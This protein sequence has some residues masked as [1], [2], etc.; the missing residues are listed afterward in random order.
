MIITK[1]S[2]RIIKE[3]NNLPKYIASCKTSPKQVT[4]VRGISPYRCTSIH[5]CKY[6]ICVC[7]FR[8]MKGQCKHS[9]THKNT[10]WCQIHP[11]ET[12]VNQQKSTSNEITHF[13]LQHTVT[14]TGNE[15]LF[16]K[17]WVGLAHGTTVPCLYKAK[18]YAKPKTAEACMQV[19]SLSTE[20]VKTL[21]PKWN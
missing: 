6:W 19:Y 12:W 10:W 14:F 13:L 15:S 1:H 3:K 18:S 11:S 5:W 8:K 21:C 17:L 4:V 2:N 20:N 7:R 16:I 9:K